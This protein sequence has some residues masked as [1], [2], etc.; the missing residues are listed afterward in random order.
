MI[1]DDPHMSA[2]IRDEHVCDV[3]PA[4]DVGALPQQQCYAHTVISDL[5]VGA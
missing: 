5:G 3:M 1:R 2:M 4:G